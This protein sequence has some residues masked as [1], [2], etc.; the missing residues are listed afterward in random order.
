MEFAKSIQS[1]AWTTYKQGA[2]YH[3]ISV[4]RFPGVVLDRRHGRRQHHVAELRLKEQVEQGWR[5]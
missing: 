1:A 5:G 3:P 2:G 4:T